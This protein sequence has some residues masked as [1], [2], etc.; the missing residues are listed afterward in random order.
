MTKQLISI[1]S[2]A[3]CNPSLK[4]V[5]QALLELEQINLIK[6]APGTISWQGAHV[7]LPLF[8]METNFVPSRPFQMFPSWQPSASYPTVALQAGLIDYHYQDHELQ[9]FIS[10][11]IT[12]TLSRNQQAWE[13]SFVMRLLKVRSAQTVKS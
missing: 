12:R 6:R 3:P 10:F 4:D 9:S 11:W 1:S 8:I 13:R 7:I 2:Y 5:E